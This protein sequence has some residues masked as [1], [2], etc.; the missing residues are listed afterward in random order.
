MNHNQTDSEP[1]Y[2]Q[3]WPWALIAIPFFTVIAGVTTFIIANDT[4]DSLVQ[5]D[6]YKKGLAINDNI[7]RL[8][9]GHQLKL[10]AEL[11]FDKD[12]QLFILTATA[13]NP[14]PKDLTL[15]FSH[16][17][18]QQQDRLVHL[19]HLGANQYIGELSDLPSAYWHISLEDKDKH[20]LIKKRW[21][22]PT[23]KRLLIAPSQP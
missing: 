1:W 20:W 8:E 10:K 19:S 15:S 4:S 9:R 16:P 21:L 6:Y 3:G 7:E 14:L 22:Y 12:N 2:K 18:L 13:I 23:K 5:D 11:E 17:T